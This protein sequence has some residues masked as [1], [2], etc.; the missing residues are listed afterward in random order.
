MNPIVA[1]TSNTLTIFTINWERFTPEE[2][3]T[4]V[5]LMISVEQEHV[6]EPAGGASRIFRYRTAKR[7]DDRVLPGARAGQPPVPLRSP[8]PMVH[9]PD[10]RPPIH[11][12]PFH[13]G[14][15]RR[16]WFAGRNSGCLGRGTRL[17]L[18][19]HQPR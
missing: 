9:P 15:W 3:F 19:N 4:C 10:A 7:R 13:T 17:D 12:R 16:G 6:F 2:G 8:V 11:P 18:E 1:A 5:W 14:P